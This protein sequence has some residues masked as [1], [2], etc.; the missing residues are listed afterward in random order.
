MRLKKYMAKALACA[1]MFSMAAVSPLA[2]VATVMA[3]DGTEEG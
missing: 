1:I 3:E 2:S